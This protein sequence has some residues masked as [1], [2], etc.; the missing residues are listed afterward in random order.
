MQNLS[1]IAPILGVYD[2]NSAPPFSARAN[3]ALRS[4]GNRSKARYACRPSGE[5]V[6]FVYAGACFGSVVDSLL[7]GPS[8][9]GMYRNDPPNR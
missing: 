4:F 7:G 5:P 2:R 3:D 8:W 6:S 9:R 1:E